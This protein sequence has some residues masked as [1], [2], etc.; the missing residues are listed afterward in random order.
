MLQGAVDV[1]GGAAFFEA[2]KAVKLM[3]GGV[4]G[5]PDFGNRPRWGSGQ[6]R[7]RVWG[8]SYGDGGVE[9]S[10]SVGWGGGCNCDPSMTDVEKHILPAGAD[11]GTKSTDG[12][13]VGV[14][15]PSG[16]G[17]VGGAVWF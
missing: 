14:R 10:V 4:E 12:S 7:G 5:G 16:V 2:L 6:V 1:R 11:K 9:S 17:W 8:V 15:E 13:G 3:K